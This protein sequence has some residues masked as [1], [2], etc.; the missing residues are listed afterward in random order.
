M[1]GTTPVR[2]ETWWPMPQCSALQPLW[3]CGGT[4]RI[5]SSPLLPPGYLT[6]WTDTLSEGGRAWEINRLSWAWHCFCFCLGACFF[7]LYCTIPKPLNY[8]GLYMRETLSVCMK[9]HIYI[10]RNVVCTKKK[11]SMH[12]GSHRR[13]SPHIL[14]PIRTVYGNHFRFERRQI[15]N[16][17]S[18]IRKAK[19]CCI[20]C[21]HAHSLSASAI[22]AIALTSK[23]SYGKLHVHVLC[24]DWHDLLLS[25]TQRWWVNTSQR[26]RFSSLTLFT[27]LKD[28]QWSWN[29]LP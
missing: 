22:R 2:W 17:N 15:S 21:Q 20:R 5:L 12:V 26:L 14:N 28:H 29:A 10:T 23:M 11:K 27:S 6:H 13:S 25:S 1:L 4:V 18:S 3:W 16:P 24:F 7:F 8:T 19:R 9:A